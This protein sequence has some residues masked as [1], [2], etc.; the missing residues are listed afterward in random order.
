MSVRITRRAYFVFVDRAGLDSAVDKPACA[1]YLVVAISSLEALSCDAGA[2][3]PFGRLKIDDVISLAVAPAQPPAEECG[4]AP[5]AAACAR[6]VG[7]TRI[8][9]GWV[10]GRDTAVDNADY[11]TLAIESRNASQPVLGIKQPEE[12]GGVT[13]RHGPY[14]VFPDIEHLGVVF[15]FLRLRDAHAGSKTVQS[16]FVTVD[17]LCP[18]T[19]S[20]EHEL[21]FLL[22]SCGMR[23]DRRLVLVEPGVRSVFFRCRWCAQLDDVYLGLFRVIGAFQAHR[24]FAGIAEHGPGLRQTVDGER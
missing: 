14:F 5:A 24:H 1:D 12:G 16:V 19:G 6:H 10:L 2:V 4:L 17:F 11:D 3:P 23:L 20:G 22:E 13:C 15:E 9:Q 21:L 8:L 7:L 18:R